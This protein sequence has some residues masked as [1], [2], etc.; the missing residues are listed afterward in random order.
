MTIHLIPLSPTARFLATQ[1]SSETKRPHILL[2][3][4]LLKPFLTSDST[5]KYINKISPLNSF[6]RKHK[7][8][9]SSIKYLEYLAGTNFNDQTSTLSLIIPSSQLTPIFNTNLHDLSFKPPLNSDIL[10]LD[11][12]LGQV[13]KY[14]SII[15]KTYDSAD[16]QSMP[17]FWSIISTHLLSNAPS[18]GV[19]HQ[20]IGELKISYIPY[21]NL[22]NDKD[23]NVMDIINSST[24]I[25]EILNTPTLLPQ[26]QSYLQTNLLLIEQMIIEAALCPL[27]Y[28][29]PSSSFNILHSFKK[30]DLFNIN[31]DINRDTEK[32]R[33]IK[34]IVLQIVDE[35]IKVFKKDEFIQSLFKS[36]PML[37]SILSKERLFNLVLNVVHNDNA[38]SNL[39]SNPYRHLINFEKNIRKN[40]LLD[41]DNEDDQPSQLTRLRDPAKANRF[42]FKLGLKTGIHTPANKFVCDLLSAQYSDDRS[43]VIF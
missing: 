5:I 31:I 34:S 22:V 36:S 19:K 16:I 43:D 29:D 37:N 42:I 9:A 10:V 30:L 15:S 41:L 3:K 33:A 35:S 2:P 1:L 39:S 6:E 8:S 7:F 18:W 25:K 21:N 24:T 26:C 23:N 13:E 38:I 27:I 28:S 40:D 14:M 20:S 12:H 11:P 4:H 32:N 17:R